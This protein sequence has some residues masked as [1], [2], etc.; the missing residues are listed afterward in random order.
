[1]KANIKHFGLTTA[2]ALVFTSG[3]NAAKTAESTAAVAPTKVALV[4]LERSAY[5]AWKS[6]D[7][8][9]W[10]TFL[11]DNFIG[12]G[13]SGRLDK[14]SATEEYTGAGCEINGYALSD[15][16]MSP[17]GQDAALITHK[18]TVNGTCGGQKNPPSSWAA[19]VYVRDGNQWK[20]AFHAEAAVV[21][22]AAPPVKPIV[23]KAASQESQTRPIDRDAHTDDLLPLEKAVWEAWKDHDAKRLDGL[24][25]TNL[26]FINIFGIHLATKAEALKNWSGEGCDVKTV[27]LSDAAA[28][29]LSPT[30][31]ILT[32]HA[33]ADGTCFGRKVGP[34]WGSSIYVKDGDTWKWSF[35]IN[36]PARLEGG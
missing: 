19:G 3:A 6:K 36:L 27:G 17:L 8:K 30:V 23:R 25:A 24:T 7:A 2:T 1:M 10:N 16:Q 28:T 31:G 32:F 29:M 22:P 5:E 34:V 15:V 11:S 21:N 14:A 18:I 12:W 26:Q 20:A 9:F 13:S 33:S 4:S 35:G